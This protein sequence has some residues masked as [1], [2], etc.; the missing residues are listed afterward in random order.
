MKKQSLLSLYAISPL[1]AGA[2][3]ATGAVDLPIQRERHT[4]WPLVQAS[5][6]KG[7][8]RDALTEALEKK[9]ADLVEVIFGKEGTRENDAVAGCL[10]LS[11]ARLLAYPM[12]SDVAPF[13]WITCPA[14]LRRLADD[15]LLLGW[16]EAEIKALREAGLE[17]GKAHPLNL[18]FTSSK[19]LLEEWPLTVG[20]KKELNLLSNLFPVLTRLFLVPDAVFDYG[21]SQCTEVQ[22]QIKIDNTTGTAQD[23]SLRYQELLPSD[24]QLYVVCLL[25]GARG[26]D[27]QAEALYAYLKDNLGAHLQLGGDWTLG[28]GLCKVDWL[29]AK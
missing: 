14:V 8:L 1:H 18:E 19:I 23:G 9:D 4:G 10:M 15:L 16:P 7:A 25:Q 24:S 26:E 20:P 27:L 13:V 22:A 6:V 28:R 2:G 5:G 17:E 29:L 11:D 12:R 3:Q 21:I